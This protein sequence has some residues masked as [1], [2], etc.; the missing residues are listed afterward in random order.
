MNRTCKDCLREGRVGP[1]LNAPFPGPRCYRHHHRRMAV[2]K[3]RE[4]DMRMVRQYGL[5]IGQYSQILS[6]QGGG[7]GWCGRPPR[8]GGRALALDHDHA[9]CPGKRSCGKCVRGLLCWTCNKMLQHLGDDL[10]A[11]QRGVDYLLRPPAR[12]VLRLSLE[13]V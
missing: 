11:L 1:A 2:V 8:S 4:L 3:A 12:V 9:C 6:A 7:C 13:N 10:G 5:G